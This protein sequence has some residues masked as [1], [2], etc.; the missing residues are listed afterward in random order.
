[1]I[2][3]PW[4]A[5]RRLR[6]VSRV[7]DRESGGESPPDRWEGALLRSRR[8]LLELAFLLGPTFALLQLAQWIPQWILG[9]CM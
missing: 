2:V 3:I 5:R 1:M 8:L 4:I 7:L 6:N 9:A